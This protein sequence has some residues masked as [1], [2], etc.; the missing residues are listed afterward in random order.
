MEQDEVKP[1]IAVFDSDFLPYICCH[2][3]IGEPIK[4]LEDC[5]IQC[6]TFIDSICRSVK[7][8]YY[9]GFRTIGKC[10]RYKVNP[11]Y[12]GNRKYPPIEHLKEVQEHLSNHH[13]FY[14]QEDYES[15]DLVMSFKAQNNQFNVIVVSPDKDI[16]GALD[17][18]YNPRKNEFVAN[19]QEEIVINQMKQL[20]TGD[21]V[22]NVHGIH[23]KGE[24][25][26]NKI[27]MNSDG[28]MVK[29][30]SADVIRTNIFNEYIKHFGEYEGIKE[31]TK[32][33]LSLK[34]LDNVKLNSVT[35]NKINKE[36]LL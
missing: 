32:N 22:D 12:K 33:Y 18:A 26:F 30:L 7:A 20:V 35:I 28:K 8:D 29:K 31:F 3:K 11:D 4:T 27:I 14:G 13:N 5:I 19:T 2:N 23:G 21:K 16:L 17:Y 34:I 24:A 10:F 25:F 36:V 6:D 15:D 9:C 1:T